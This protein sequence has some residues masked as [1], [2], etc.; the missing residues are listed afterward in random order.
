MRP[1]E[2]LNPPP[3]C[4]IEP[5]SLTC[6]PETSEQPGAV[7][8]LYR[9]PDHGLVNIEFPSG[10]DV[11]EVVLGLREMGRIAWPRTYEGDA[12]LVDI[13]NSTVEAL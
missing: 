6:T 7:R 2:V 10:K 5:L 13:E 3:P 1:N 12:L 8:L 9:C 11:A 4:R